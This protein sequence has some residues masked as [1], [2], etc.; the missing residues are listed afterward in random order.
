M[1]YLC[2]CSTINGYVGWVDHHTV[3]CFGRY[4]C[5]IDLPVD[6]DR[7]PGYRWTCPVRRGE[8]ESKNPSP[9]TWCVS[10]NGAG[11]ERIVDCGRSAARSV[12]NPSL[13][14]TT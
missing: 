14:D 9:I 13:S 10:D 6:V 2:D 7:V 4:I 3:D 12:N 8:R 11:M 1:S 5:Y